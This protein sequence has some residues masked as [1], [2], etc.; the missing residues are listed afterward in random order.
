MT[1]VHIV[2]SLELESL[3]PGG[4]TRFRLDMVRDGMGE[5]IRLPV[6]VVRGGRPG[7]TVGLTAAIHGNELNGVRAVQE[8]V[9]TLEPEAV[10]GTVVAVPVVNVPGYLA[11]RREF[12]DNVD[13]NRIMPG[14]PRGTMS[15]V[16]AHRFM[17]RVVRRL[18][19]LIDLHTA[20]FGRVNSLYVRADMRN[21]MTAHMAYLQA[22]EIIVHNESADGTLRG[23]AATA[24]VQ[25][26]TVELG[27]PQRFQP[28]RIRS[29]V[30]GSL[31]VLR[32]LGVV[33]GKPPED[34]QAP[35]LCGR[36]YWVYT[37]RG[38]L[39]EVLPSVG[40]RITAGQRIAVVTDMFGDVIRE[41]EAPEDGVV[42]GKSTNPV[43]QAG[44]RILH[45]GVEGLPSGFPDP[46]VAPPHWPR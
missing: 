8:L 1:I 15:Q 3:P 28:H 22:P 32:K 6:I 36:S 2:E 42:V 23:A 14:A 17:E 5:A 37:D 4:V 7:P 44:S 41:Y 45:L 18:D 33:E 30:A 13:L 11:N 29:S 27:D 16:Y 40:E 34:G 26:I 19:V 35:L 39:L 20:S 46:S 31:E 12:N 38:G 9:A 25:A 10:R 43:N 21:P 24:G